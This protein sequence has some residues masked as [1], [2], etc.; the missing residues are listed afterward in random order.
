V[1]KSRNFW[2]LS[3]AMTIVFMGCQG[4]IVHIAPYLINVG[5]NQE[6][7]ALM[8]GFI[9]VSSIGGR[10]AFSWLSDRI[11]RKT[12]M[13]VTIGGLAAGFAL[14]YFA[15]SMGVVI[16]FLV[17]FGSSFGGA[18]AVRPAFQREY[19]GRKF[20]GSIQGLTM[21]IGTAGGIGGPIFTGW[22]FD[23]FADYRLAWIAFALAVAATI[24]L[25]LAIR[26]TDDE[27]S[28]Q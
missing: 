19:F 18:M 20:F 25:I 3:I 15:Q 1:F 4:V 24:P 26:H 2:L 10:L 13:S 16:G 22:V 11:N 5:F 27:L 14:L 12:V 28:F 23:T 9:P 6:T 21:L 17:L 8:A 7:A